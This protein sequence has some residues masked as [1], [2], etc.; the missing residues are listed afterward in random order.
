MHE[1]TR[2]GSAI[3]RVTAE[4]ADDIVNPTSPLRFTTTNASGVPFSVQADGSIHLAAPID[5]EARISYVFVAQV[6]DEAG[7]RDVAVINVDVVDANDH[8]PVFR[9]PVRVAVAE[10]TPPF[11]VLLTLTAT[12]ADGSV[13]F[14]T[15]RY[16]KANTT[17]APG[18]RVGSSTGTITSTS[19]LDREAGSLVV[20]DIHAFDGGSPALRATARVVIEV[21]RRSCGLHVWPTSHGT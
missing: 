15:V 20:V 3:G 21:S 19:M 1:T 18:I 10:S 7:R 2:V 14:S 5:Y 8:A 6:T 9:G 16:E 11:T 4:D 13:T 12:D 17:Q